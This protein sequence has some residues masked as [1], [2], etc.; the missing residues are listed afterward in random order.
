MPKVEDITERLRA[1]LQHWEDIRGD[2]TLPMWRDWDW[3]ELPSEVIP[4]CAVVDVIDDGDDFTHRFW[5]TARRDLF[6]IDYTGQRV[7]EM[8]PD[9]VAEKSHRELCDVCAVAKPVYIVTT[10]YDFGDQT[11]AYFMLRL[12]FGDGAGVSNVL[13]VV[14]FETDDLRTI[15][16]FMIGV[17]DFGLPDWDA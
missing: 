17:R 10:G 3:L 12:P 9:A 7:S 11:S 16:K 13:S 5:G 14:A 2:N 6:N 8:R 1:V 15:H 4:W